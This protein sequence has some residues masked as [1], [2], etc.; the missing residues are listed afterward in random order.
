M[1]LDSP[2]REPTHIEIAPDVRAWKVGRSYHIAFPYH[3]EAKRVMDGLDS[4]YWAP[5][6][7]CWIAGAN[8]H[9]EIEAALR[10]IDAI[11]G[12]DR[13][14]R[15]Q[16][17][18]AAAPGKLAR[19]LVPVDDGLEAGQVRQIDGRHVTVERFGREFPAGR[20]FRRAGRPELDGKMICYAYHRPA[21]D[22]EIEAFEAQRDEGDPDLE[23]AP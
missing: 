13:H 14:V 2:G 23:M 3:P 1:T 4:A 19:T 15:R 6:A 12:P 17:R 5:A 9:G 10:R 20:G 11:L 7:H 21:T 16:A 18:E 22:A 8:R